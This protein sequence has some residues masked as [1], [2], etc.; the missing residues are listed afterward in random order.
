MEQ[1]IQIAER[2]FTGLCFV[3]LVD[4]DALW[5]HRR[6]PVGY[7]DELEKF[8]INL[9]ILLDKLHDDDLLIITADHGNDPTHSGTDHTR[10]KVPFIAFSPSMHQGGRIDDE[11]TF[12]VIGATI[13]DNFDLIMPAGTIGESI[14]DKIII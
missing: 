13:T 8:D 14:L 2:D 10:E 12:A 11:N 6:N 4:F 5:G 3:N 7:A 9:G 1:T